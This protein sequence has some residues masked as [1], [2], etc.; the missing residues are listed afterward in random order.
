MEAKRD[1][2]FR[3]PPV[4]TVARVGAQWEVVRLV[5]FG[6]KGEVVSC[7]LAG[8]GDQQ[9]IVQIIPVAFITDAPYEYAIA[10]DEGGH[11]SVLCES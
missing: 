8:E 7:L 6:A 3:R 2:S 1:A 11:S 9:Q 5:H 10:V 4:Q